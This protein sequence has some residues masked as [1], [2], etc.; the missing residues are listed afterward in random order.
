MDG[1]V[2]TASQSTIVLQ[3]FLQV[4]GQCLC[5]QGKP[6]LVLV[7]PHSYKFSGKGG[8]QLVITAQ[9]KLTIEADGRSAVICVYTAR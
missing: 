4:I 7:K 6:L 9:T 5:R 8:E 1:V 2:D 3:S